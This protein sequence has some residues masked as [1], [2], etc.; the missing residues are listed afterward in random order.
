MVYLFISNNIETL[1]IIHNFFPNYYTEDGYFNVYE[2]ENEKFYVPQIPQTHTNGYWFFTA[3]SKIKKIIFTKIILLTNNVDTIDL[4]I[5]LNNISRKLVK[6]QNDILVFILPNFVNYI[7]NMI[8]EM[9]FPK[10]FWNLTNSDTTYIVDNDFGLQDKPNKFEPYYFINYIDNL[11]LSNFYLKMVNSNKS[12]E[13]YK[14]IKYSSKIP[15]ISQDTQ[16][17]N[18]LPEPNLNQMG[19]D[20]N[21]GQ[22]EMVTISK[23]SENI[24]TEEPMKLTEEPIEL[25]GDKI[26]NFQILNKS[27]KSNKS[28]RF[29]NLNNSE[30]ANNFEN[31]NTGDNSNV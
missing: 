24:E 8:Y 7:D 2:Y 13:L 10:A 25:T 3:I 31:V 30:N 4:K 22:F 12:S 28:N 20:E 5:Y 16:P 15:I 17:L 6:N 19:D 26:F 18:L 27:N 21:I 11:K 1:K 29:D 14:S 9:F 23:K